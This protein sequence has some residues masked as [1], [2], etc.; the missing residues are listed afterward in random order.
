MHLEGIDLLACPFTFPFIEELDIFDVFGK[1][2]LPSK[3]RYLYL[4]DI[5]YRFYGG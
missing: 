2:T 1:D 3:E 5:V 4:P